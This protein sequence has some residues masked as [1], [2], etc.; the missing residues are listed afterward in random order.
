MVP[1]N[2]GNDLTRF[3]TP[4]TLFRQAHDP[5]APAE[6]QAA[7]RGQLLL[8]YER[9]VRG[10]LAGALRG[11]ANRDDLIGECFQRFSKRL[12]EGAFRGADPERGR[13]RHYLRTSLSNLVRQIHRE[14]AARP[15]GLAGLE[16]PEP[17]APALDEAWRTVL[18]ERALRALREYEGRTGAGHYTV[19][20][21]KLD[22][23]HAEEIGQRLAGEGG[24]P[25]AAA[26]VRQRLGRARAKLVELLREEVAQTL[27]D[28]TEEEVDEELAELG[29]LEYCRSA[30]EGRT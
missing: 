9:V 13:F 20:K 7:A 8:R 14:N 21:L 5:V 27:S 4:K 24:K 18:M 25:V 10:Y 6:Q 28:P 29:L 1:P 16:L 19:L 15:A 3:P 22:G 26:A 11:A 23:L 2:T 12:L 17:A 30:P